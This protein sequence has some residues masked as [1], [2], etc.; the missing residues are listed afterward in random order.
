MA[1]AKQH[2]E[3][4]DLIIVHAKEVDINLV[5]PSVGS[6]LHVACKVGNLK[7]A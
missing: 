6:P 4:I 5:S 3:I 2:T 1:I 7:I